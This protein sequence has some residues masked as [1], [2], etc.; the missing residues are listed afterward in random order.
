[1]IIN[2]VCF[3]ACHADTFPHVAVDLRMMPYLSKQY[4]AE[5]CYGGSCSLTGLFTAAPTRMLTFGAAHDPGCSARAA[6][7]VFQMTLYTS[8]LDSLQLCIHSLLMSALVS[9]VTDHFDQGLLR[10]LSSLVCVLKA[11]QPRASAVY[12]LV[13]NRMRTRER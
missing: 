7:K 12:K 6:L 10:S 1:M 3:S 8:G 9:L 5:D 13:Q 11:K 2:V 4:C